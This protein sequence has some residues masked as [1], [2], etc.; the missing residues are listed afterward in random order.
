MNVV[1]ERIGLLSTSHGEG[2]NYQKHK[3]AVGRKE[4]LVRKV[5][6]GSRCW[7]ADGKGIR[8]R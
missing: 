3:S 7:R 5:L 6:A 1:C 8:W 4:L 2:N